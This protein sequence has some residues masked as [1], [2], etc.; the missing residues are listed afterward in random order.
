MRRII[1]ILLHLSCQT[2]RCKKYSIS[3]DAPI[4]AEFV[5][6]D[7]TPVRS[8]FQ[9]PLSIDKLMLAN[10]FYLPRLFDFQSTL[11][12]EIFLYPMNG[13]FKVALGCSNEQDIINISEIMPYVF[14]AFSP[15]LLIQLLFYIP[16][17]FFKIKVGKT[18]VKC[19]TPLD[20]ALAQSL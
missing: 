14:N 15:S 2:P 20:M 10:G 3:Q 8:V 18:T 11:I 19:S 17:E 7:I 5:A 12:M 9:F 6:A 4:L 16:V 1:A 13:F